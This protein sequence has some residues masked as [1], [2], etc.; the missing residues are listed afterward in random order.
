MKFGAHTLSHPILSRMSREEARYE[1]FECKRKLEEI[2]SEKVEHFAYPNGEVGDFTEAHMELVRRA[3]FDS[4]CTT[5]LGLN[6]ERTNRYEIR[7]IY[8]K[9]E[10]LATFAA[11]L[12]GL[13]S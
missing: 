2:L 8:A 1:I 3:G 11:R 7:R 12:V 9:E 10:P 13:G 5:I 6:D 4:A